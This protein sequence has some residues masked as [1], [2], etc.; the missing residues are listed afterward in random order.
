M[1]RGLI[2]LALLVM[3]TLGGTGCEQQR[4]KE[5]KAAQAL[6]TENPQALDGRFNAQLTLCRSIGRKTGR[7]IGAGTEFEMREESQVGAVLE[8]SGVEP[9][10]VNMF[11]LVWIKPGEKEIFRRY[12]EVK[13]EPAE[14]GYRAVIQW[15]K[16]EDRFWL[17]EEVQES[18]TP[19]FMLSGTLDTSLDKQREPGEYRYRVYFNRELLFDQPF[20]LKGA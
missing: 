20:T 19:S 16:F 14:Q 13:V 3:L 18:E 7:P 2:A 5:F 12:A 11:H 4:V 9:G 8:V 15:K 17:R 6:L 1:S 10:E